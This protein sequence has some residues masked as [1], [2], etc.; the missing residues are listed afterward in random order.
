[1]VGRRKTETGNHGFSWIFMDFPSQNH[2]FVFLVFSMTGFRQL[3][4]DSNPALVLQDLCGFPW[5]HEVIKSFLGSG[6]GHFEAL[7]KSWQAQIE[8]AQGLALGTARE[9]AAQVVS[10]FPK[11]PPS[12]WDDA[13][14]WTA[15]LDGSATKRLTGG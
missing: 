15:S 13:T 4:L 2:V 3:P 11:V 12:K 6:K 5:R 1:M 7:L 14:H 10:D 8:K 9:S